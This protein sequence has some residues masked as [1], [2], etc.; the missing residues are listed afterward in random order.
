MAAGEMR[1]LSGYVSYWKTCME[2]AHKAQGLQGTMGTRR[3]GT[4]LGRS[5]LD[6]S[7]G[8]WQADAGER[9]LSG[10]TQGQLKPY[11]GRTG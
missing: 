3:A 10:N 11:P 2:A 8:T 6:G 9:E 1:T 7:T 4:L 5:L